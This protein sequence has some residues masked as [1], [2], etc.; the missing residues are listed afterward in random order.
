[1]SQ[2]LPATSSNA[3]ALVAD[4]MR[5]PTPT[6]TWKGKCGSRSCRASQVARHGRL[7][8]SRVG[9]SYLS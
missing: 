1:V 3:R 5:L 9:T 8:T 6:A 7:L 2:M 4:T